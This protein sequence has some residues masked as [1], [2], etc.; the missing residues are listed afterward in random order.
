MKLKLSCLSLKWTDCVVLQT[1]AAVHATCLT[2]ATPPTTSNICH[3]MSCPGQLVQC[4]EALC[5]ERLQWIPRTAC[6]FFS[7]NMNESVRN[8]C[9][10]YFC[11]CWWSGV[12]CRSIKKKDITND[13]FLNITILFVLSKCN[14]LQTAFEN[15]TVSAANPDHWDSLHGVNESTV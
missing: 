5:S 1:Y 14:S 11:Q 7:R 15:Q 8:M 6:Y 12:R 13:I 4:Q 3:H 9:H 10:K 2:G